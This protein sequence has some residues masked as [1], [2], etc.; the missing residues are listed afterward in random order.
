MKRFFIFLSVAAVVLYGLFESR[1]LLAGPSITITSPAAGA[2]VAE[3]LVRIAGVAHNIAFLTINDK[4]AFTDEEGNFE[5][6]L[7]PPGGYTVFTVAATDRFGR[8]IREEVSITTLNHCPAE[9]Y[10]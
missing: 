3:P 9:S 6:L 1:R 8:S 4:P 10:A 2:A 7:T 5:L